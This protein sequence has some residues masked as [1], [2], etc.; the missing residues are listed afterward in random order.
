[1]KVGP[2][3]WDIVLDR[4]CW[5]E[6]W[7]KLF[8]IKHF[9]SSFLSW[10]PRHLMISKNRITSLKTTTKQNMAK[11]EQKQSNTNIVVSQ[12]G[13]MNQKMFT[14]HQH[15]SR[16]GANFSCAGVW[17]VCP[18]KNADFWGDN[19]PSPI[20]V[21]PSHY[22]LLAYNVYFLKMRILKFGTESWSSKTSMHYSHVF[23][24]KPY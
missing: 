18:V 9:Y 17:L 12:K 13:G 1:M 24:N 6:G 20:D 10:F 4:C 14:I 2:G 7:E 5:G 19:F 11:K 23:W 15:S 16:I 3:S 8:T 21:M 22:C